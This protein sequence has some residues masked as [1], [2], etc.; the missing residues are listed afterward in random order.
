[1]YVMYVGGGQRESFSLY[2]FAMAH[3]FGC[4]TLGFSQFPGEGAIL[5]GR[6][7]VKLRGWKRGWI[8]PGEA[9]GEVGPNH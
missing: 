1:M 6:P 4:S 3:S 9:C 8:P 5:E 2:N 7:A